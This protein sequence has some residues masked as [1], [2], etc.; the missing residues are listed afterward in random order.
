MTGAGRETVRGWK[1]AGARLAGLC[2]LC[3]LFL[4]GPAAAETTELT[5]S[6]PETVMGYT[7]C[8]IVIESPV[9]GEAVLQMLDP[10]QN[11]WLTRKEQISAGRNVLPWDGLGAF[12]E[13]MFAGPYRFLVKVTG[14]DGTEQSTEAKFEISGTTQTLVYALPSSE[15]LYL[16]KSEKWFVECFVSAECLVAME[17]RD[18]AGKKVYSRDT[19]VSDPD[20]TVIRA[21]S[22][23][24]WVSSSTQTVMSVSEFVRMVTVFGELFPN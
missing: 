4:M 21:I 23:P 10:L 7:P 22:F 3:L 18:S 17:V 14:T 15:A 8:E 12:G 24:S 6:V 5:V 9:A 2:F 1:Q 19:T 20:G 16:D 11:L 13:R